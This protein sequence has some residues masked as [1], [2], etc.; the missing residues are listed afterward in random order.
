[1]LLLRCAVAALLLLLLLRQAEVY[2]VR[3]DTCCCGC[4]IKPVFGQAGGR[5]CSLPFKL[6]DPAT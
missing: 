5:C 4:C 1:V 6:R 2:R 3:P